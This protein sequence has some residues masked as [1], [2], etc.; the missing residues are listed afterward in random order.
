[1]YIIFLHS[2]RTSMSL[3]GFFMYIV[4]SFMKNVNV[5]FLHFLYLKMIFVHICLTALTKLLV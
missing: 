5:V 1:M 2:N 3:P 4:M